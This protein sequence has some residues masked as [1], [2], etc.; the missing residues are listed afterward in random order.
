MRWKYLMSAAA[1]SALL[2][3]AQQPVIAQ[4]TGSE[5]SL[6]EI[7]V[8][9]RFRAESAQDIG[10]SI[11]ALDSGALRDQGINS[12]RDLANAVPSLN[13]QDRGPGRNEI[14][15]RGVGRSVFQQDIVASAANIG[16][17]LDDVPVNV[18]QGA[19]IDL[20]S[21]DLGRVEVL[22]GPQG[23]LF[24][25]GAQGGAIRYFSQDP[26][27]NEFGGQLEV[28]AAAVNDGDADVGGGLAINIPISEDKAALRIVGNRV[29]EP[30][31]ID[32][33]VDGTQ[34]TN[35]YGANSLRAVFLAEPNERLKIRLMGVYSDADQG[36][37]ATMNGDP[38]AQTLFNISTEGSYVRD[39]YYIASANI[40]YKF[41][42]FRIESITSYFERNRDRRV[43][44]WCQEFVSEW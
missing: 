44:D 32:N 12:A 5:F 7:L 13:L 26:E 34:N 11:S 24:G 39:E 36:A 38:D 43:L 40:S 3:G 23:T 21:F 2:I 42:D 22:R 10:A 37:F 16:V 19:Q 27:Y 28:R 30:G 41:D 35:D 25:E 9:A 29:V 1:V 18:L 8:T 6:E 20:R 17:Y 4:D 33:D 31:Y 15:I 14:S